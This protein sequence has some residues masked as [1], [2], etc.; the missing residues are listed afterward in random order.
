M[1]PN[2]STPAPRSQRTLRSPVEYR[3]VGLHSG[4][5][6]RVAVR[7]AEAGN[8][9]SFIR[10]DIEGQPE[11]RA[12][13]SNL[14]A[15]Q[16]RTCIQD[17][18]AEV[19]TCEHLLASLYALGIDNA[20]VEI[21]GEE[22]PGMDGAAA[23]FLQGLKKAGSVELKA[24]RPM[25]SV[26]APIYVREGNASI[27]ALPGSGKLT[28]EYHLEYGAKSSA[29]K[30]TRQVVGFELSSESFER[31]IASARTFVFEHEVEAL[32]AAASARALTRRILWSSVPVAR[33]TTRCALRMN[34]R[35]TRSST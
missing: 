24:P 21:D 15:R 29:I 14:K 1:L 22:V 9:V 6:I 4:K 25:F 35:G 30:P 16:R 23:D 3:G 13:G 5:E 26:Q 11:V 10:T 19:Y 17:G 31:E 20:V 27:V 7:P 34:W 12:Q 28:V 32:R 33:V 2:E 18:K 8:G